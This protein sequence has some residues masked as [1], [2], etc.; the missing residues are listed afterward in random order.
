[1]G[2]FHSYLLLAAVL[3][4][5]G[6]GNWVCAGHGTLQSCGLAGQVNDSGA[7]IIYFFIEMGLESF[8]FN[9]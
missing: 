4:L 8:P 9:D 7:I 5:A 1:M 2:L 6:S 3:F